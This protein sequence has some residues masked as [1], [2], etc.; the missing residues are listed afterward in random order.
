MYRERY[1]NFLPIG[2]EQ[3]VWE[4][5]DRIPLTLPNMLNTR[6]KNDWIETQVYCK[7]NKRKAIP[8]IQQGSFI[9]YFYDRA[10][11]SAHNTYL[12]INLSSVLEVC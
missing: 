12:L 2:R 10:N 8:L 7:C 5:N 11:Q 4:H 6:W 3:G 9:Y 1:T